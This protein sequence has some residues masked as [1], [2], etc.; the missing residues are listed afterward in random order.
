VCD[1]RQNQ[2][3]VADGGEGHEDDPVR[4]RRCHF[5]RDAQR[6]AG[7]A[8]PTRPGQRHQPPRRPRPPGS[9]QRD[10]RRGLL[11]APHQ[12]VRWGGQRQAA[13]RRD[14]GRLG[15][16]GIAET[17]GGDEDDA[18]GNIELERRDDPL[19]R[20]GVR[21]PVDATLQV[22]DGPR[23]H[24]CPLGQRLLGQTEGRATAFEKIPEGVRPGCC[25]CAHGPHHHP[26]P[27]GD[28]RHPARHSV[29]RCR[30]PVAA[31]L[32]GLTGSPTGSETVPD[33]VARRAVPGHA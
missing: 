6:Q 11:V 29:P 3:G 27:H 4:K 31:P 1:G 23:A 24:P 21:A 20:V 7:L 13:R 30:F 9:Q 26:R 28:K 5:L 8:D 14:H 2:G 32:T 17:G 12:S 18:V 22:A 10:H 25:P 16:T 15:G 19:Q 33:F